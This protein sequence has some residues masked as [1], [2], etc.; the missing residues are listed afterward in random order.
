LPPITNGVQEGKTGKLEREAPTSLAQAADGQNLLN[1]NGY[2]HFQSDGK[3]VARRVILVGGGKQGAEIRKLRRLCL[4][5]CLK[6][7]LRQSP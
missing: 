6:L 4:H 1:V 3:Q 2:S 5:P 7:I